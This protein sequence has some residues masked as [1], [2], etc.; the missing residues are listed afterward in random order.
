MWRVMLIFRSMFKCYQYVWNDILFNSIIPPPEKPVELPKEWRSYVEDDKK[1]G[2]V[3]SKVDL[4][5]SFVNRVDCEEYL[6]TAHWW[7]DEGGVGSESVKLI[8]VRRNTTLSVTWSCGWVLGTW[9]AR[10]LMRISVTGWLDRS[11]ECLLLTCTWLVWRK[12]WIWPLLRWWWRLKARSVLRSGWRW[13]AQL[14]TRL[15]PKL[16]AF[17]LIHS[18]I[19]FPIFWY[20]G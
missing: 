17:T 3:G 14:L 9:M 19:T 18:L 11:L 7:E 4:W 13:L 1:G 15:L 5:Y 6:Q 20:T 8:L 12:W 16:Y 10:E 2:S